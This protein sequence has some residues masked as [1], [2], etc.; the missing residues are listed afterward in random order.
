MQ[1]YYFSL[2]SWLQLRI[3]TATIK[4]AMRH[5]SLQSPWKQEAFLMATP[6]INKSI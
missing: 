1:F 2:L 5:A 6:I 4:L 3:N